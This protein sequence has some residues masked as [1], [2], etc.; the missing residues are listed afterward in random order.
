MKDLSGS[1]LIQQKNINCT[2]PVLFEMNEDGFVSGL[3]DNYI[4]VKVPQDKAVKSNFISN[5]TLVDIN[6]GIMIGE[7]AQ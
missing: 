6:D 1:L 3:T 4:R 5:V 7:I 2:R